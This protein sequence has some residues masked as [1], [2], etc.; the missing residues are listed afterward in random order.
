MI[1]FNL[2]DQTLEGLRHKKF[3]IL[4]FQ[5]HPEAAPGP[6]DA[7]YLFGYFIDMM[8]KSKQKSYATT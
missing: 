5:H 3:P 4:S 7:Q 8:N 6:H 2:N 1:D